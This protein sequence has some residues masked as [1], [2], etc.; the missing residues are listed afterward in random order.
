M[1][2][3]DRVPPEYLAGA[4]NATPRDELAVF[5]GAVRELYKTW[6]S[7]MSS[8]RTSLAS[9]NGRQVCPGRREHRPY[10]RPPRLSVLPRPGVSTL[11]PR[12]R[13]RPR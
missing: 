6:A 2:L 7:A 9:D 4:A 11:G 8:A 10:A 12:N 13:A 3:V 5:E 1:K